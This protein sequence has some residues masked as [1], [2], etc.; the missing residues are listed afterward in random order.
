MRRLETSHREGAPG[1]VSYCIY[2]T[3]VPFLWVDT[4]CGVVYHTVRVHCGATVTAG[5]S[6]CVGGVISR[7][8]GLRATTLSPRAFLHRGRRFS[9]R[10]I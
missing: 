1:H 5:I 3:R 4:C 2:A 7:R 8:H 9:K 10:S 6:R